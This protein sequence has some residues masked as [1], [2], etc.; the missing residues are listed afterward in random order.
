MQRWRGLRLVA[1]DA[2]TVGF[3]LRDNH[4]KRAVLADN[5]LFGQDLPGLDLMLAASLHN[6]HEC[7]ERQFLFDK[8]SNGSSKGLT[9]STSRIDPAS[10]GA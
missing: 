1:A 2:S 4:V 8:R 3:G 5:I 9:W 6:V 10:R 7:G